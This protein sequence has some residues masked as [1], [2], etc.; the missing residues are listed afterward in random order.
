LTND[1]PEPQFRPLFS[2]GPDLCFDLSELEKIM[3][4][5]L[6]AISA[7]LL[8]AACN[9]SAPKFSSMSH[10]ELAEYNQS[11][12]FWNKI[13]CVSDVRV[14]SHIRR[15]TCLTYQEMMDYN[16]TQANKVNAIAIGGNGVFK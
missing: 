10:G 9:S 6:F 7:L 3:Q 13:Y 2:N 5:K 1:L 11:V 12:G 15:S 16:A 4:L 8:L 14:G